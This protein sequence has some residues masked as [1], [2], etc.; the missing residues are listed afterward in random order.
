MKYIGNLELLNYYK[1]G[2]FSSQKNSPETVAKVNQWINNLEVDA[3]IVSGFQ[4]KNERELLDLLLEENKKVI[5]VLSREIY[6]S[7]PAKY[8]KAVKDGKM[9]IVSPMVDAFKVATRDNARVRNQFVI[10]L[11]NEIIVGDL[12][13]GGMLDNMLKGENFKILGEVNTEK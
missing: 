10:K 13:I 12:T 6:N 11:S 2:F 9:L 8:D 5:M 3:C 1:V 7:C 4:S